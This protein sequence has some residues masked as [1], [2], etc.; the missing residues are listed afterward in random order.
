MTDGEQKP[1]KVRRRRTTGR[2]SGTTQSGFAT[3]SMTSILDQAQSRQSDKPQ[4]PESEKDTPESS[5]ERG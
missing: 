5:K 1:R 4:H 2:V 3:N